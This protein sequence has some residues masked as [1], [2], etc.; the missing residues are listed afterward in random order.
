M[1]SFFSGGGLRRELQEKMFHR[2]QEHCIR[3][4]GPILLHTFSQVK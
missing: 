1:F 2:I 4:K 3:R